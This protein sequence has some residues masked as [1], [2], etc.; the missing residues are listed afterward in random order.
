MRFNMDSESADDLER[1]KT[2]VLR[3]LDGVE[4]IYLFGSR[5]KG[6]F[7][8]TSDYDIA[9]VVPRNPYN[10]IEKIAQIR[11]ALLGK[12][13][14]PIDLIILDHDDFGFASP[15]IFEILQHN[16]LI[17]G[18]DILRRLAHNAKNVRPIV[19]NNA[20]IGYYV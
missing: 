15:V 10:Y 11:Y 3:E 8:E 13:K 20:T 4:A 2:S 19:E 9:I 14:R 17:F 7:V 5:V 6:D 12:I 1:I 16:L 18:R